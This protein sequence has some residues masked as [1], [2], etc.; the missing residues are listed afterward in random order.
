MNP[1]FQLLEVSAGSGEVVSVFVVLLYL[2]FSDLVFG[3]IMALLRTLKL[4]KFV[5]G[6]G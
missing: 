3:S 5:V 1:T 4:L 6:R 2:L